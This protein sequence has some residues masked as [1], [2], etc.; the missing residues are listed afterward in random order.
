MSFLIKVNNDVGVTAQLQVESP[1]A[2]A[3]L[4]VSS[5]DATVKE[6][7]ILTPGEVA[8][9]FLEMQIYRNRPLLPNLSGLKLEYV[10]LQ[11]YCKD[12]G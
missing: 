10:V 12:E 6:A 2:A 8:S 1:N 11:I 9:R 5:M 3:P 7:N 4:P